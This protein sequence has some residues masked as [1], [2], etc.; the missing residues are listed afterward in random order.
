MTESRAPSYEDNNCFVCGP[1][2]PV[3]LRIPFRM[4]GEVCLGRFTPGRDHVGWDGVVHGGIIFSALDD[5]MAN[6]LFLQN[7]LGHTARCETRFRN[8]LPV[9]T[10]VR[11][12]GR[13]I[14]KKGRVA[15]LEGRMIRA[16]DET[17]IAESQ[18]R[19]VL[20]RPAR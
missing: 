5:V 1:N 10:P 12:E 7:L 13:L 20:S 19:F 6:W 4:E 18:G 15:D 11:L 16:D 2:N 9:E 3:G 14:A 8:P 17:V